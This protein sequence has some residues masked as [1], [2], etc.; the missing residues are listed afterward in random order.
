MPEITVISVECWLKVELQHVVRHFSRH[1]A[2][3]VAT[4]NTHHRL[5]Q[6][7]PASQAAIN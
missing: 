3:N 2:C 5:A 6:L 7:L 1:V 4:A